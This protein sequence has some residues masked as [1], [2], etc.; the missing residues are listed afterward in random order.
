MAGL[1]AATTRLGIFIVTPFASALT[2][3]WGG[4]L[5]A[6]AP[7]L[8]TTATGLLTTANGRGARA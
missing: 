3:R 2:Q 5:L 1:F 6:K 4:P 8:L 7:E